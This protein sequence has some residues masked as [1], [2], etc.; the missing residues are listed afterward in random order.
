LVGVLYWLTDFDSGIL[1]KARLFGLETDLHMT[2]AEFNVAV[3]MFSV[4]HIIF[5]IPSNLIIR[6]LRPSIWLACT[7]FT[8]IGRSNLALAAGFGLMTM[9]TGWTKNLGGLVACRFFMGLFEAG[10]YPGCVYLVSMWY[11]R[12]ECYPALINKLIN[13]YKKD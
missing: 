7:S 3:L 4:S 6:R 8:L 1:S 12:N 9:V 2:G 5:E 11:K 13:Q 10:I